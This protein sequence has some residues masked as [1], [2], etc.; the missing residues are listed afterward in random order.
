ME[1]TKTTLW[2]EPIPILSGNIEEL[3]GLSLLHASQYT[4][5]VFNLR[6]DSFTPENNS[7]M[8]LTMSIDG[9]SS[10]GQ[11]YNFLS[12]KNLRLATLREFLSFRRYVQVRKY[13]TGYY[14]YYYTNEVLKTVIGSSHLIG[15][16]QEKGGDY[17]SLRSVLFNDGSLLQADRNDYD[18]GY[19]R[20]TLVLPTS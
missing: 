18:Y 11:I 16:L 10:L 4:R 14:A 8:P 20:R 3:F 17:R 12:N 2:P 5:E 7:F 13:D 15:F 19:F 9:F 6:L 1:N